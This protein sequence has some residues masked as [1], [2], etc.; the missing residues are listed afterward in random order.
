MSAVSPAPLFPPWCR[1]SEVLCENNITILRLL[2]EEVFDFSKGNMTAAKTEALKA[3]LHGE[4]QQIFELILFILQASSRSSL[5]VATLE[6]LQCYVRWIPEQYIFETPLLEML[7]VKF[8]PVAEFRLPTLQVITEVSSL[9]KPMYNRIFELLYMGVM[10]Q[11]VRVIPPDVSIREA[12]TRAEES[13][14]MES[15][16]FVRHLALY[17]TS[18]FKVHI[19]LLEVDEMRDALVSGLNYVLQITDVED[20]ET[21]KICLD[22]WFHLSEDLYKSATAYDPSFAAV[23]P[24]FDAGDM[25]GASTPSFMA[26][27][28]AAGM[29]LPAASLGAARRELY[30]EVLARVRETLIRHM[31]KPEEV[32]L[33]KDETGEFVREQQKDT[34]AIALYKIMRKTMAYLTHLDKNNMEDLM[35]E[36]LAKQVDGSEWGVDP[37]NSL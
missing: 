33:E 32:L 10:S 23:L 3:S 9:D 13:G 27:A 17:L 20:S 22:L 26:P 19:R 18:Y 21:F 34:D 5:I 28:V 6:C 14:D 37:L 16:F 7:C 30:A 31:A 25:G 36:K 11:I 24:S 29:G 4:L 15:M 12:Y 1:T 2:S 8:L 35:L